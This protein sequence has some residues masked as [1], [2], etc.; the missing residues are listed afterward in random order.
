MGEIIAW[1]MIALT[2]YVLYQACPA[3]RRWVNKQMEGE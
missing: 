2:S 3:Y 1:S